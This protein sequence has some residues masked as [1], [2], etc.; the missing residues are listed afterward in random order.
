MKATDKPLLP[1][2]V[3]PT[4]SGKSACAVALC[5]RIGGEVVS[6]DSMQ[7]YRGMGILSAAPSEAERGGIPHHLIGFMEPSNP[8]SADAYRA[9]ANACIADI[10]A[11]GRIPVLCGGTGLYID[12]VTRPMSFSHE[13]DPALHAALIREAETPGGRERLHAQLAEIDPESAA[14]LHPN[15]IRRVCR[16]IEVYRLTGMTLT[17]HS[18]ADRQRK[19][20]YLEMLFALDWDRVSLYRRIDARVDE[21]VAHGLIDEVRALMD[22]GEALPTAAQAIGCRQ[23]AA[24]LR[25][26]VPMADA[27]AQTKRDSRVY[28]KRQLT[29][30]RRDE[31]VVWLPAEG[32][33]PEEIAEEIE[34]KIRERMDAGDGPSN[35]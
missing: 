29:W 7:I 1:A 6:A 35:V 10:Q 4:A 34:R 2:V 24:A 26:D 5:Q 19:G 33:Y 11:R 32:R 13:S 9:A 16:A 20:D 30:F 3:G 8:F 15:D 22:T 25:G 18:A 28:A 27:I 12:A 31:R 23:I 14:R 17:A 21:M